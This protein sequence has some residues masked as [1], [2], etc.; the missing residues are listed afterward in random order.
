MTVGPNNATGVNFVATALPVFNVSGKVAK[1][2]GAGIANARV[3]AWAAA[4]EPIR[5]AST[6]ATPIPNNQPN[7]IEVPITVDQT[8]MLTGVHVATDISYSSSGYLEVWVVHPDGTRV[9]LSDNSWSTLVTTFPDSR[10]PAEPL[11]IL[12]GRP[13]SGT[14]KL[15]VADTYGYTSSGGNVNSWRL[16]LDYVTLERQILT[17]STGTYT[18]TGLPQGAHAIRAAHPNFT[19]RPP[20]RAVNLGPNAAGVDFLANP[21]YS[22]SGTVRDGTR[23]M[24]GV[25]VQIGGDT[26]SVLN[27]ASLGPVEIQDSGNPAAE[28]TI[29]VEEQGLLTAVHVGVDITHPYIGD[30]RVALVH[31]DGT[32]VLLQ[33]Q[34]GGDDRD[35]NTLFPDQT[36]PVQDLRMLNGKRMDGEWT[37]VVQDLD[38]G[39]TGVLNGW[40][41]RLEFGQGGNVT[42]AANGTYIL[43]NLSAGH[44]EV[45]ASLAGA[46]FDPG[47]RS[48][49]LGPSATGVD[50]VRSRLIVTKAN[51]GEI[52]PVDSTQAITWS[53]AGVPG[54]VKIDLSRDGGS[55]FETILE[56]TPNDGTQTWKVTGPAAARARIRVS[57]VDADWINDLS[58]ADFNIAK[59]YDI[60]GR[61]TQGAAGK[62]GVVVT[63][64]GSIPLSYPFAAAPAANIPDNSATGVESTLVVTQTGILDGVHA[65]V[66]L[67]HPDLS[68]VVVTLTHPDG[69]AVRLFDRA[70][71]SNLNT[72]YPDASAPFE[73]L[74]ALNGKPA[75]GTWR[76]RV[77]DLAEGA[78]GV[79]EGWSLVLDL[80]VTLQK[81]AT[82]G[83]TGAYSITGLAQAD[84]TVWPTLTGSNFTPVR[85]PVSLGPSR[86]GVD[87]ATIPS[88]LF[89]IG[90]TV[91]QGSVGLP[92]VTVLAR[93]TP[94]LTASATASPALPIPPGEESTAGVETVLPIADVGT[95]LGVHVAVNI[96]HES[97]YY[98]QVILVHPD[99]TEVL[100]HNQ[101]WV[102]GG[103][104]GAVLDTTYPDET[105]PSQSLDVLKG[106][107]TEGSWKVR[108]RNVSSWNTYTGTFNGCTLTLDYA[109]SATTNASGAYQIPGLAA[110]NYTVWPEAEG[111]SFTP[112]TRDVTLGPSTSTAHFVAAPLGI[113]VTAPTADARW[114]IGSQQTIRWTS[115]GITGNVAIDISRNGGGYFNTLVGD[116]ANDGW[117]Q[118]TVTG[119]ATN[120]AVIR[121]RSLAV[122]GVAGSSGEFVIHAP[123][124][125]AG[126]VTLG[127]AGVAGATVRAEGAFPAQVR[128]TSE[129]RTP[130]VDG[131]AAG[132]ESP[133]AVP[134][135]VVINGVHVVVNASHGYSSDVE[136]TLV[137]PDGTTVRLHNRNWNSLQTTYPDNTTPAES[138]AV[139]RGKPANGTWKLLL[140]DIDKDNTA[141]VLNSWT[142]VID[143]L[144]G[145]TYTATTG[146]DGRYTIAAV[147]PGTY[148]VSPAK[149]GSVFSPAS[150]SV[151]V[152]PNAAGV[153]FAAA[154]SASIRGSVSTGSAG[155]PGV[156]VTAYGPAQA[157][158]AQSAAP[159][160]A[161]PDNNNNG[162]RSSLPVAQTGIVTGVHV[163]VDVTHPF[164]SDLRVALVHPDGTTVLLHGGT[165][166]STANLHKIYPDNTA[167]AQS[168]DV[169]KGKSTE[170]VW[171]LLAVDGARGDS[172]VLD[173]WTLTLNFIPGKSATTAANGS[174]TIADLWPGTYT[175]VPRSP[176]GQFTPDSRTAVLPP[177]RTGVNFVITKRTADLMIKKEA[178]EDAAFAIPGVM[179][180]TPAGD[181]VEEQPAWAG[182]PAVYHVRVVNRGSTAGTLVL[183]ATEGAGAGWTITYK[184]GATNISTAIRGTSGYATASLSPGAGTTIT[185]I[186]TPGK[187]VGGTTTKS[188]VVASR[189]SATDSVVRD[190][191]EAKATAGAVVQPDLLI[192]ATAEADTAYAINNQYQL[193][194]SGLQRRQLA[195]A[196]GKSASYTVKLE[197]DG[198]VKKC[199]VLRGSESAAPGW[200]LA[201]KVG[202]TDISAQVRSTHGYQTAELLPN[203]SVVVA[204]VMT[205]SASAE[206]GSTKSTVLRAFLYG[207]TQVLDAVQATASLAQAGPDL[208]IKKLTEA[209]TA[210]TLD[211]V[212][213][214]APAGAQ[215]RRVTTNPTTAAAFVVRLQ[216]DHTTA[217]TYVLKAAES[218][219]AGWGVV[220]KVG[221]AD[222]TPAITGPDGY[223]TT[224]IAA[225]AAVAVNVTLTPASTVQGGTSKSTI[226]RVFLSGTD[227]VVRDSVQAKVTVLGAGVQAARALAPASLSA[228]P[229]PE[230]LAPADGAAVSATPELS[231]TA[232]AAGEEPVRFEIELAQG[233]S[234][235]SVE[236]DAV[237]AGAAASF[238][239]PVEQPLAAGAW[240]WR[241][242]VLADDGA[243]GEWSEGRAFA[244]R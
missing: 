198:N 65:G 24:G 49:T 166:G 18:F 13:A 136:I 21:L 238:A 63:A 125:I 25:T 113:R 70:P 17:A 4:P 199:F 90:G 35:L 184:A 104:D 158:I 185:V 68:Q 192:R 142:L 32:Q 200:T 45:S 42:T 134:D 30:L 186:L 88:T 12:E 216:N 225:G 191:V 23:G 181:Q 235:W 9:L 217:R 83:S 205:P 110:G 172:G 168:L 139:L 147:G 47:F 173:A 71:G 115:T 182:T 227:A 213:Q 60:A 190:A 116:T 105:T 108:V 240:R 1:E 36:L 86:T 132:T 218:L 206:R 8:G 50:F 203:A 67:T 78:T 234:A 212:Y 123:F 196:A 165:G 69:T 92:D 31:P 228:L 59:V 148:V 61:V 54:N 188:V 208:L 230:L 170:G 14:W 118:W 164:I 146:A 62:A 215:F 194:P 210:F 44:Y 201:Y 109:K 80:P 94:G 180:S 96:S 85:R 144:V 46:W 169:L 243:A 140:K 145:E 7:G 160:A 152:G 66:R 27:Q 5:R 157:T 177:S 58:D 11:S 226:V 76:L 244:V 202:A 174:Y 114:A 40:S 29:N 91:K 52:W 224:S 220:Y 20:L 2:G 77:R 100:L 231:L 129:V 98:V 149:A 89:S 237:P 74:A 41:L 204:V 183:K 39:D 73:S 159:G 242:R 87:F 119:D 214:P 106:K 209:D 236:T 229:V 121:V 162:V 232:G 26:T 6:G 219:E 34:S 37:L 48:V 120:D 155:V 102:S 178:E 15:V 189:L 56:N 122:P 22:I 53:K 154:A 133:L 93:G 19:F 167:P 175:V 197:N 84:Y 126:K 128:T 151:T 221:S 10:Q 101:G 111:F 241:A 124:S 57:A 33:N 99:G 3:E 51:G 55:T 239:V 81:T 135:T 211:N 72:T 117:E 64:K 107:P 103:S 150:R 195:L 95:L 233:G 75:N 82:T 137:H 138:L 161:I 130:I 156:L 38:S 176:D 141:G 223:T 163:K 171:Q 222:I 153:D 97:F 16:I 193:V 79:L 207:S 187:A 43:H 28:S 127:T 179:Q 131:L 112:P 143:H